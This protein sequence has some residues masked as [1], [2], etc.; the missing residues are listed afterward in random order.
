MCDF[1]TVLR[2]LY[3]HYAD[4]FYAASYAIL[5]NSE[6]AED[7][8]GE[9][10]LR[11]IENRDAFLQIPE[12]KKGGLRE[13]DTEKHIAGALTFSCSTTVHL[14]LTEKTQSA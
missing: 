7:A 6:D 12:E 9:T 1:E 10:F 3:E 2:S 14:C 4:R 8:V 13:K 5:Q 11:L